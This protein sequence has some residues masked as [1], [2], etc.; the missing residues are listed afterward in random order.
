MW[1]MSQFQVLWYPFSDEKLRNSTMEGALLSIL[2]EL[3][4]GW[5]WCSWQ[6]DI[7]R[8]DHTV[9]ERT[10]LAEM[11]ICIH[12]LVCLL[13]H[14]VRATVK[15]SRRKRQGRWS[16]WWRTP[17][18]LSDLYS[19]MPRTIEC[20]H[21]RRPVMSAFLRLSSAQWESR[22]QRC[23]SIHCLHQLRQA[24]WDHQVYQRTLSWSKGRGSQRHLKLL[25]ESQ[26][27]TRKLEGCY[28]KVSA[29]LS[30]ALEYW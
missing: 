9:Q 24:G 25:L 22:G 8:E 27:W 18:E 12:G 15:F 6:P 3:S 21:C 23:S 1:W 4:L 14:L 16:I 30:W 10:C 13:V 2:S 5:M 17:S 26:A 19:S 28:L 11:I 7:S 20:S 29:S